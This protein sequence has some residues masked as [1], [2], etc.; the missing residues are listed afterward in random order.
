MKKLLALMGLVVALTLT[1]CS[2]DS[3]EEAVVE[4]P[5]QTGE[6]ADILGKTQ[7]IIME[8]NCQVSTI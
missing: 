7:H 3:S 5:G 1:G 4:Q 2:S 8:L 6:F